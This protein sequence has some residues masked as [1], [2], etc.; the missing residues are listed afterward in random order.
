MTYEE[1]RFSLE[2][3]QR[4]LFIKGGAGY[5]ALT[6]AIEA[7]EKQILNEADG[8]TGCAFESYEEWQMPC[9]K[10]RRNN[11]DYWRAEK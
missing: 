7:L 11:K 9:E 10:C 4:D 5:E 8:C 6:I 2:R 1:A 3:T